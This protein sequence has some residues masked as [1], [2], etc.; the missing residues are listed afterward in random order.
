MVYTIVAIL[1]E[2]A[3]LD[4]PTDEMFDV[5]YQIVEFETSLSQVIQFVNDICA[6]H[7]FLLTILDMGRCFHVWL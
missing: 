5:A 2:F 3:L 7:T 6:M 4:I 1:S